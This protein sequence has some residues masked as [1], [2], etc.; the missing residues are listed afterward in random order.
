MGIW[1]YRSYIWN[2]SV[3]DL[4]NR[5]AGSSLGAYWNILQPLIQ[6]LL[7]TFVFSQ[8]MA[9]KIP[10]M[11]SSVAFAIY[12]SA[13]FI[14]WLAFSEMINRGSNSFV[15]NATY[16]K[17]LA[18]PEHVFL[19]QVAITTSL[20]LF[21]SMGLLFVLT[22]VL[23]FH[24]GIYWLVLPI[25]LLLFIAFGLGLALMFAS[26][27]VFFRDVSQLLL[28]IVQ[29]WMWMTPIVYVEDFLPSGF[30]QVIKYNPAYYFV[31]AF[32]QIIVYSSLPNGNDWIV[33]ISVSVLSLLM[34]YI[35]YTKLRA[36]IRDV[37]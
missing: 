36:E 29:I 27:N 13:G 21:I 20:N 10:G 19:L 15:E 12:L 37:I 23:G 2:N 35:V 32:H 5:Y 25:V 31:N 9:A 22:I 28:S 7:F 8:V 6:I 11:D 33:M 4:K 34:G 14:P 1:K 3:S 16:L 24:I 26:I 18:I 30:A 17:K